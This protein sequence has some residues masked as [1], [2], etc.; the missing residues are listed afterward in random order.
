MS[1]SSSS[2]S[3]IQMQIAELEQ[4][5]LAAHPRLPVLLKDIHGILKADPTNVTLLTEDE[6]GILVSGLK[7]QTATEIMASAAKKKVSLKGVSLDM[8]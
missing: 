2:L 5:I 8:L 3:P 6:I 4:C 7:R 1:N